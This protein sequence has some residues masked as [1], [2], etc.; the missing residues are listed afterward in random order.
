MKKL[1]LNALIL[2]NIAIL[3]ACGGSQP[4]AVSPSPNPSGVVGQAITI[5]S[6]NTIPV[7]RNAQIST[8]IE[9]HNNAP[10]AISGIQYSGQSNVPK[11]VAGG[12]KGTI[13]KIKEIFGVN[14]YSEDVIDPTS[15]GICSS[16]PAKSS[17]SLQITTPFLNNLGT[18]N[19]T[20]ASILINASYN[21][22]GVTAKASQVYNLQDAPLNPSTGG[23][24]CFGNVS[25][26]P[27]GHSNAF[28]S[29][30][31]YV[32]GTPG[33]YYN[34]DSITTRSG[35]M[36]TNPPPAGYQLAVGSILVL[37]LASGDVNIKNA[38]GSPASILNIVNL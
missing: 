18:N 30:Y 22:K 7:F 29:L 4:S 28:G 34:L 13:D 1:L 14:V 35:L 16:I 10:Y 20:S 37:N 24:K 8:S 17:C 11:S 31:C 19:T 9:I 33:T 38:D 12:L 25:L 27:H 2:G 3:S 5:N 21:N 23:V 32:N 36:V 6:A 26:Y 15:A